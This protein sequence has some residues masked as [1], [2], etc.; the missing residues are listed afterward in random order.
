LWGNLFALAHA[1]SIKETK[2]FS[3]T[4]S[5]FMSKAEC[6][7]ANYWVSTAPIRRRLHPLEHDKQVFAAV[8]EES[9]HPD[10]RTPSL[11]PVG[12]HTPDGTGAVIPLL[13]R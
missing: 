8:I 6:L 1:S 13:T 11:V 3:G 4:P 5:T 9:V 2:E 12:G 10:L 7:S